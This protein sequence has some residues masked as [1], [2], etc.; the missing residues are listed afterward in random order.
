MPRKRITS[1]SRQPVGQVIANDDL[2]TEPVTWD[3][4]T[5]EKICG[6]NW[7]WQESAVKPAKLGV[8]PFS[9]Q[10]CGVQHTNGTIIA[11][12]QAHSSSYFIQNFR[13]LAETNNQVVSPANCW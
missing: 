11:H 4:R 1:Q 3:Q 6:R 12:L 9:H 13:I 2:L 8:K 10:F 7:P 5:N